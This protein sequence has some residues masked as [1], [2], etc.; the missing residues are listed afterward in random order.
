MIAVRRP[1]SNGERVPGC[2]NCGPDRTL[3]RT[4]LAR[5]MRLLSRMFTLR[6]SRMVVLIAAVIA[7]TGCGDKFRREK[8]ID[9]E[10]VSES[11]T[12]GVTS[13]ILAPGEAPPPLAGTAPLTGT[14][15]DTTT[16][17]TI[18]DSGVPPSSTVDPGSLAGTLP[19]PGSNEPVSRPPVSPTPSPRPPIESTISIE[20]ST[21]D[22]TATP[23]P[24]PAATETVTPPGSD[25]APP[26][27]SAPVQPA[28]ESESKEEE[29]SSEPVPPPPPPENTNTSSSSDQE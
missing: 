13:T 20:R 24:P 10:V 4:D 29:P 9:A 22:A 17:F 8:Q 7:L 19:L 15:A 14:N 25:S 21:P 18:L 2:S 26:A 12:S 11:S 3:Y 27:E 16:A 23:G 28:P 5:L 1:G 6:K